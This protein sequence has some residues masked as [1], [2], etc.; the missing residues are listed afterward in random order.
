MR[1]GDDG[2]VAEERGVVGVRPRVG[3]AAGEHDKVAHG[4]ED[5]E[6]HE[7]AA[8]R[9]GTPP[10]HL[11]RQR[12]LDEVLDALVPRRLARD[13]K[14]PRGLFHRFTSSRR[15]THTYTKEKKPSNSLNRSH[16]RVSQKMS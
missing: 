2:E 14:E 8:P 6:G 7:R 13:R 9:R 10:A 3:D 11:Q 12:Q 15:H 5:A 16:W 1:L 4:V